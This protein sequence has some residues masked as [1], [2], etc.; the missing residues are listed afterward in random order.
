VAR[1][2]RRDSRG[3]FAGGG[4]GGG[5]G[6]GG[7][8]GGGKKSGSGATRSANV[9][10]TKRLQGQGLTGIGSR[11]KGKNASLYQG[12]SATRQNRAQLWANAENNQRVG[13]RPAQYS[14]ARLPGVARRRSS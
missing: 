13:R 12:T 1:T 3:R 10:T 6:R 2:Y 4:G 11:L 8:K 5:S 9:A 7:S 14:A